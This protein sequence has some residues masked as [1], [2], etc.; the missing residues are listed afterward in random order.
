MTKA[1]ELLHPMLPSTK[2]K[3]LL[4]TL[5]R[6]K[7]P[8]T[9]KILSLMLRDLSVVNSM[10]KSFKTIS[11]SGHSLLRKEQVTSHSSL[12]NSR[13]IRRSF[14]LKKSQLWYSPRWRILER[15][16]YQNQLRMLSLQ[17]Q[18]ISMTHR[19]LPPKMLELLLDSMFLELSMSPQLQPLLTDLIKSHRKREMS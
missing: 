16:T 9:P 11:N 1:T 6:I 3:D 14:S 2:I 15:P 5:P 4:V 18:P 10:I 17:S 13:A 8:E 19:E 7:L 12:L